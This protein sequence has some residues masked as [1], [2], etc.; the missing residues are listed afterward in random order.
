MTRYIAV[1]MLALALIVGIAVVAVAS[2]AAPRRCFSASRWDANDAKRPCVQVTRIAED[3]S[4][5]YRVTDADG[6]VRY[7]A[8]VGALDR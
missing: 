8:G 7:T 4:F 1:T 2:Q 6:V 3:G 5:S